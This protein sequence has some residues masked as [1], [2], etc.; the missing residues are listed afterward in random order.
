MF[1]ANNEKTIQDLQRLIADASPDEPLAA[2]LIPVAI[3]NAVDNQGLLN[4]LASH[5]VATLHV[6]ASAHEEHDKKPI[7]AIV[8]EVDGLISDV[9]SQARENII[10]NP[11]FYQLVR[12]T[13][14]RHNQQLAE[15]FKAAND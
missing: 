4:M 13:A 7:G 1:S 12:E 9:F 10:K 6:L 5:Y 14:S 15:K 8:I 11:E 2:E 3:N